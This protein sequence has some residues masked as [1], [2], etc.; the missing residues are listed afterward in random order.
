MTTI[1]IITKYQNLSK[2]KLDNL[3]NRKSFHDFNEIM[4]KRLTQSSYKVMNKQYFLNNDFDKEYH[5]DVRLD[6]HTSFTFFNDS[7]MNELRKE[8]VKK[9]NVFIN[10]DYFFSIKDKIF[11]NDLFLL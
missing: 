6:N 5:V 8:F 3:N 1:R 11:E 7:Y 9:N 2:F 4:V 10:Y